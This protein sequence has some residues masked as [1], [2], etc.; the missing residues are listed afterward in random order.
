[1]RLSYD[2]YR[3]LMRVVMDRPLKKYAQ[4]P[5]DIVGPLLEHHGLDLRVYRHL[6]EAD[7]MNGA[8]QQ[9]LDRVQQRV[10]HR[11][12][13]SLQMT[14]V[15]KSISDC[16][17]TEEVPFVLLGATPL[18]LQH[19]S[20]PND[21]PLTCVEICIPESHRRGV[22]LLENA[23]EFEKRVP[24][25][26]GGSVMLFRSPENPLLPLRVQLGLGPQF[27]IRVR[28]EAV[29]AIRVS[30]ADLFV[31]QTPVQW[32]H[33]LF[34]GAHLE[35]LSRLYR[36]MDLMELLQSEDSKPLGTAPEP[37]KNWEGMVRYL[38]QR[39]SEKPGPRDLRFEIMLRQRALLP[40]SPPSWRTSAR[41]GLLRVLDWLGWRN[42]VRR[43]L[44]FEPQG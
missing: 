2:V 12:L 38:H 44:K 18:I 34:V 16:L 10:R 6:M 8:P 1:M 26:E 4:V 33:L 7:Q 14:G 32:A 3:F 43:R 28:Q 27:P 21:R 31:L 40:E 37:Y 5:W 9:W 20:E 22:E 23:F 15:L 29:R 39:H 25:K 30:R 36:L 42:A 41:L 35:G 19:Y 13:A 24:L 17:S 11:R